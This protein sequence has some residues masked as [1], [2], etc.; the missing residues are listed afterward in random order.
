MTVFSSN[1]LWLGEQH[2]IN[3]AT[4]EVLDIPTTVVGALC[5]ISAS[6]VVKSAMLCGVCVLWGVSASLVLESAVLCDGLCD[7]ADDV[8]QCM[9]SLQENWQWVRPPKNSVLISWRM[10]MNERAF[11]LLTYVN[12]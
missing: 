8:V 10:W 7:D 12:V 9:Y 4:C 1:G 11:I 2:S 3:D 5:V 6:F